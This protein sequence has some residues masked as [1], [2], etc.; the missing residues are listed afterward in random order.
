MNDYGVRINRA[1]NYAQKKL[2]HHIEL[3]EVAKIAAFSPYYF[4]RI[5]FLMVG[6]NF[7]EFMR[8]RRL[9]WA[10]IELLTS[11]RR[12]IDIS[13]EVGFES[14]ESF[15]RAFKNYFKVTPAKFRKDRYKPKEK[16]FSLHDVFYI[17]KGEIM[18]PEIIE[19]ESFTVIGLVQTYDAPDFKKAFDQ[20][21]IFKKKSQQADILKTDMLYGISLIPISTYKQQNCTGIFKYLT[22]CQ[23]IDKETK[24]PEDMIT[25]EIPK[26]KYA[27]YTFKGPISGFQ[28]FI[29]NIWMYYLPASGLEVIEAPEIEVYD[30]RINIESHE[31]EMDYLIPIK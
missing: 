27:K 20:W 4:H 13:L 5:F 12:I 1:L 28:A 24:I 17:K 8:K 15:S 26:Q 21:E 18:K 30:K 31:S 7:S 9:E 19:K 22:A 16:H 6:E 10:A 23:K 2:P 3:E 25:L 14:Q 11:H 29:T